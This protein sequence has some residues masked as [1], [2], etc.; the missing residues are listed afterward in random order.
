MKSNL[1]SEGIK[2]HELQDATCRLTALFDQHDLIIE[3]KEDSDAY[4]HVV[5]EEEEDII[6]YEELAAQTENEGARRI[7]LSIADEER[8][9]LIIVEHIYFFVES[10]KNY[11]AN[12]EFSN[13]KKYD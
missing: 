8:K 5:K 7:L 12:A 1:D 6:F 13:L 2:F 3:L 11:L 9:H 10:P 4:R